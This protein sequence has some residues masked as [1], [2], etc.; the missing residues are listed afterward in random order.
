VSDASAADELGAS[1]S[2]AALEVGDGER[3][4]RVGLLGVGGMGRVYLARDRRLGRMVALKEAHDP[5]LA[6]RLAR[7]VRVTAG[8][9]HPGIV[10]VYD[11]GRGGDGRPFYTMRL[12]R[13]RALSRVL[14]ERSGA[15]GRLELLS[16]YLDACQALAYAHAQGVIH[17]DLKPANI[18]LGAFGETQVVDWGLARRLGDTVADADE[19]SVDEADPGA[20][21]AGAVLGTPAYM[22]PEQA[23]GE[24]ADR[25]SDVWGLGAVLHELVAG[26]PPV[27]AQ[28]EAAT[29]PL[30]AL[31]PGAPAELA[32]IVARALA[33]E[34]ADRYPDAGA[35][36][37]DV[38]AYLAGRRVHAH[39]YT[40]LELGLRFAR[41]W[42]V[43]LA[44]VGA[45]LLVIATILVLGNLRLRE[46]RDRALTAELEVRT[47][48][49][50]SDHNLA[51]A[52]VAQARAAD[53]QGAHAAK[54]VISAHALRLV[55]SPEAR[56]LIAGA[57]AAGRPTRLASAAA[58]D[59]RP[60]VALTVDDLVCGEGLQLRR[61][62]AGREVWRVTTA[63]P[64]I[65][66]HVEDGRVWALAAGGVLTALS[67]TTGEPDD[68]AW[69]YIDYNV[70]DMW[71]VP[72]AALGPGNQSLHL[73]GA[74]PDGVVAG[75]SGL[76]DGEFVILCSDGRLGR[77]RIPG[78]PEVSPAF[79]RADFVSFTHLQLTP[80]TRRVVVAG[81]RGRVAVR[82][83]ET[84]ETWT[85]PPDRAI[86]VRRIVVSPMSDRVAILRERGGIEL[87]ELPDLHPL[88]TIAADDVRDIRLFP[89]GSV[90]VAASRTVTQWALPGAPRPALLADEHGLSGAVFAPDGR[91]LLTT[92]GEGRTL[93][94]DLATGTRRHELQIGL[95]TV[96]AGTFLS[97]GRSFAVVDVGTSPPGPHVYDLATGSLRWR[98]PLALRTH[99][100]TVRNGDPTAS[101]PESFMARR[102]VGLPGN[103]LVLALYAHGIL[104]A[105]IDTGEDIPVADCPTLEWKDLASA[106]EGQRAVL[107]SVDGTV[108]VLDPGP[109]LR[110]RLIPAPIGSI[111]A[112]VSADGEVVVVAATGTLA[113][114]GPAGL[115]WTVAHPGDRALDVSL[116]PDG[117]RV[118]TAGPDDTARI[119]DAQ[120]GALQ[121]VL[122]GHTA[123][124]ASVD[125]SPDGST[126][127]TGSWDGAAR[128]WNMDS[129][130]IDAET[131]VREAEATWGL[132]LDE[133]LGR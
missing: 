5:G 91:S 31:A 87:Y 75:V 102:I 19:T 124:V 83:L 64:T 122:T 98:P 29:Q 69:D 16:H 111:A 85:L 22:S 132:G 26:V 89:D 53:D 70:G 105:D 99:W 4:T 9:E 18:M 114:T 28:P 57:R 38:A 37:A 115:R 15:S 13:G 123:R 30:R 90:L 35:L 65:D 23:R 10:T 68:R 76:L 12:M 7:E 131:L 71:P 95:G 52:L 119:W 93:L 116:S 110:C 125:F 43:P 2:F 126:L 62:T 44:I 8:L 86:A 50:T 47:A 79:D 48:L 17:R 54:E 27:R 59:C 42:R 73:I 107:V 55:D 94:W 120:T 25:R 39:N 77:A 130:E 104:A 21:R 78:Q 74:C 63:K 121:A 34:P 129:L 92:H 100:H 3:Y 127:A 101:A 20:T 84:R 46:Q 60:L 103:V 24:P 41:V 33:P 58:P 49:T 56:G 108:A 113:S 11:E 88:G 80:D 61:L 72:R 133:A 67:L 32:A 109:P 14:S 106:P 117:R 82:D 1:A 45:A 51:T 81:T 40:A 112:D 96:K 6:R 118:A 97:D 128:L 66:L 36:A